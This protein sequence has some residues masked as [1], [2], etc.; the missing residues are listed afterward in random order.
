MK[1]SYAV[2]M[3][4]NIEALQAQQVGD[5]LGAAQ[6]VLGTN[7][8]ESINKVIKPV[9]DALEP[10]KVHETTFERGVPHVHEDLGKF[11]SQI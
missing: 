4:L 9:S 7:V 10:Y 6:A 3:L 11:Q 5:L 1:V 2:I 8:T